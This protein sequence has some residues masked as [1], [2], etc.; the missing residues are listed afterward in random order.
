LTRQPALDVVGRLSM[1][2]EHNQPGCRTRMRPIRRRVLG[3]RDLTI[4]RW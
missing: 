4:A 3:R 1:T 2:H